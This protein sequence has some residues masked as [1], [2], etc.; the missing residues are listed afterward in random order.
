MS[1]ELAALPQRFRLRL[2]LTGAARFTLPGVIL[3]TLIAELL[4]AERKYAIFGGGFGQSR[5]LDNPLEIGAFC[6]GFCS[7]RSS[8]LLLYR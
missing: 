2:D 5:A 6:S 4:L 1:A 3:V 7:A 8:F